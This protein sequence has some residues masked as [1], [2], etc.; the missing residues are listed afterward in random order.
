MNC[1]TNNYGGK[2]CCQPDECGTY[3][4]IDLRASRDLRARLVRR[5]F[6]VTGAVPVRRAKTGKRP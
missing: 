2:G 5:G 1:Y 6:R 3:V 4:T